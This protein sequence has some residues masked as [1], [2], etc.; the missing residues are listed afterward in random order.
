MKIIRLKDLYSNGKALGFKRFNV[1]WAR[2]K[3]MTIDE[4]FNPKL[5]FRAVGRNAWK[6]GM[7]QICRN[8]HYDRRKTKDR[9][10]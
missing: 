9:R 1:Q 4:F 8:G 5:G 3:D 2:V 6:S 10:I 7:D